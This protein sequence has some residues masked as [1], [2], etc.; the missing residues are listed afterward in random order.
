MK[1]EI[2][3]ITNIIDNGAY[4][5]IPINVIPNSMGINLSSV[6]AISW[7]KQD[8]GQLVNLQIH[9]IPEVSCDKDE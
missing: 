8:D 3:T 9:F 5:P 7:T 1:T 6:E 2:A 4:C